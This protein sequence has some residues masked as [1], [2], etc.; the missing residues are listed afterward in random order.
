M[1]IITDYPP[2][3]KEIEKVFSLGD[4]HPVFTYGDTIYNPHEC[5]L[6]EHLLVH[7]RVH[8]YQQGIKPKEWWKK[9]LQD[10]EFRFEQELEAYQAQYKF[11]AKQTKDRNNLAKFLD[12]LAED[13]SGPM[14]GNLVMKTIAKNMIANVHK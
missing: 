5:A 4:L 9:Y 6:P 7:E 12:Q 10:P 2:N 11:A 14:Y 8:A 3:Y 1:N 13:L